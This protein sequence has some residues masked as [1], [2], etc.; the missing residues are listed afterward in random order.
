MDAALT[1]TT[2]TERILGESRQVVL[3]LTSCW[4]ATGN[5]V[6][7]C[8]DVVRRVLH[9]RLESQ[10]ENPEQRTGFKHADLT[11]WIRQ[12]RSRLVSAALTLLRAYC[13]AGMPYE[14]PPWGS[15][16]GWSRMVRGAVVF[17]GLPDPGETRQALAES[18][19][20]DSATI[21]E[22]QQGWKELA[23]DVGDSRNA[24]TPGVVASSLKNNPMRYQRIRDA[25]SEVIHTNKG[26]DP[27]AA[28]IGYVLRRYRGRVT[29]GQRFVLASIVRGQRTWAVESV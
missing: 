25:L 8:G 9:V 1:G 19:D 21:Y 23:A 15:I 28:D 24:M 3:P 12:E 20:T 2:W 11:G 6:R 17:A 5:H 4:Y 29:D 18:S 13:L 16:E 26:K 22:L 27:S 14:L 7:L 10:D